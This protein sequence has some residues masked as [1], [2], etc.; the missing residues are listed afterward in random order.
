[1]SVRE[2][3]VVVRCVQQLAASSERM[4]V[5]CGC[6][7]DRDRLSRCE[8]FWS[9]VFRIPVDS[10]SDSFRFDSVRLA[11]RFDQ[12][13]ARETTLTTQ[14][15]ERLDDASR[16]SANTGQSGR[17]AAVAMSRSEASR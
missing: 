16:L 8:S 14:Q 10:V 1:M 4:A 12:P 13:D 17:V 9:A 6:C 15:R 11:I 3:I 5:G 7:C 2:W